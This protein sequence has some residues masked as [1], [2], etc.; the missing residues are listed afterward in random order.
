MLSKI[1]CAVSSILC[2]GAL[3]FMDKS[4]TP[5]GLELVNTESQGQVIVAEKIDTNID[6]NVVSL[7]ADIIIDF[8]DVAGIVRPSIAVQSLVLLKDL[9]LEQAWEEHSLSSLVR[10]TTLAGETLAEC[11]LQLAIY[12]LFAEWYNQNPS[13][14]SLKDI[15]SFSNSLS[16]TDSLEAIERNEDYLETYERVREEIAEYY[17]DRITYNKPVTKSALIDDLSV[18]VSVS[19]LTTEVSSKLISTSYVGVEVGEYMP[20]QISLEYIVGDSLLSDKEILDLIISK[21]ERRDSYEIQAFN[22]GTSF[23]I[24]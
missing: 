10:H 4:P 22:N 14:T 15:L 2:I 5:Y 11:N 13:D 9:S 1:V 3:A 17:A 18:T 16:S 21:M 6:P 19:T 7:P 23:I 8:N 24:M 12:S 20:V